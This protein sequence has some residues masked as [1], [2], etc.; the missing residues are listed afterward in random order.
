[1]DKDL[2][3]GD[4]GSVGKYDLA[5]KDDVVV[6]SLSAQAGPAKLALSIELDAKSVAIAGLEYIKAK[7]SNPLV[8]E[9]VALAEAELAKL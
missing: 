4:L 9:A 5:V 3:G 6:A 2:V 8:A 7:I 1:M